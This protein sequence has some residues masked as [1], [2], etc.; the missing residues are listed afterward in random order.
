MKIMK[1]QNSV[2]RCLPP[3]FWPAP[4]AAGQVPPY[5]SG[6]RLLLAFL[7]LAPFTAF[8]QVTA[9]SEY[10]QR[11]DSDRDGKVS[12]SEYLDWMSYAFDSRDRNRDAVLSPDE[13]PGGKGQPL[14]RE[15]HRERLSATF[16]KQDVDRNGFL[17]AKELA[18][19]PQ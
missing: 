1:I 6:T 10:L 3:C 16:R 13:L 15:Q 4:K 17:S 7:Y 9:T 14:T 19:P 18:A 12:Q 8:A 2:E 11:M 5:G